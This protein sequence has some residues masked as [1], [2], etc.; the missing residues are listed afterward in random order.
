MVLVGLTGCAT[1]RMLRP[2][3]PLSPAERLNLGVSYERDGK[4][5]LALREYER[6]ATGSTRSLALAYQGNVHFGMGDVPEAERMYRA[7]L[8]ADPDNPVALNNL[9]W[10]LAQEGRSLDEAEALVR[11]ALESDAEPRE[12]F[13]ST[14]ETI[15]ELRPASPP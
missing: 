6:A 15:L 8:D 14:L 3:D 12:A 7:S 2:T 11:R 9:A 1:W 10:L 5:E 13:E 4:P